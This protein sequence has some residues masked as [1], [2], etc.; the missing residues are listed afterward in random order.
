MSETD[1]W[2]EVERALEKLRKA[3]VKAGLPED[4]A[5]LIVDFVDAGIDGLFEDDDD[6]G[7]GEGEEEEGEDD[8]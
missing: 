7:D 2:D 1:G 6:D 8:Q 4:Q 3:L 5:D